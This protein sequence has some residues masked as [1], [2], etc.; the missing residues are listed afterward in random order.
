MMLIRLTLTQQI[1]MKVI[2]LIQKQ[3]ELFLIKLI[4]VQLSRYITRR[5]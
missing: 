3:Q 2:H 1:S 5:L 4:T